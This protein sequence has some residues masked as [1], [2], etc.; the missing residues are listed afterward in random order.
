MAIEIAVS[1]RSG[2]GGTVGDRRRGLDRRYGGTDTRRAPRRLRDGAAPAQSSA[3]S[4]IG[5]A[6]TGGLSDVARFKVHF[7]GGEGIN[8][9]L[10]HDIEH[11]TRL[12]AE[13]V[14]IVP[15]EQ[16]EI[17][18]SV[19]WH[20]L[21]RLPRKRLQGKCVMASLADKPEIVFSRPEYLT[22][23]EQI[24][25]WLCEYYDSLRFVSNCGLPCMLFPDP[26]DLRQFVPPADRAVSR[27]A[28][29]A[30]LG[31]PSERYLI[32]SFHRDTSGADLTQPKKQKG[33]DVLLELATLLHRQGVPVHFL[34]AGPRRHWIRRGFRD[35]G[36]PY[37]FLGAEL[38][39]D[40]VR[41]NT[42]TLD[43]IAKLYQG[44]DA[45]L[46]TSR[47]EGAPNSVLECAATKT[48]VVSTRVG[49]S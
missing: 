29:K 22:V 42:L 20:A 44:L 10:D 47:W 33:A 15:L 23:R 38:P 9:A 18:H 14:E 6:I 39:G 17:V 11:L 28:L 32:G 45:Y 34:L 30:R 31:I 48:C 46:I 12:S 49:Q 36:I 13:F 41:E 19:F 8:W 2:D 3:T 21:L 5:S 24:D 4:G 35:R 7:T 40:D 26:I 27:A 16:A 1:C 37:T 25:V 43:E